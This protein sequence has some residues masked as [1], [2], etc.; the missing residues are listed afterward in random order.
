M[1]EELL[2]C[3]C[4]D[5]AHQLIV[6]YDNNPNDKQVY[7]TV[8][9]SPKQ[10]FFKRLKSGLKY[11]FGRKRSIYG[12]F[13]EIILRPEDAGK[14]QK[15]VDYLNEDETKVIPIFMDPESLPC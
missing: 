4:G 7:V 10:K 1:Q 3:K 6:F 2:I 11:I 15:V 9:L 8:H 5:P 13:D 14:L 12:D